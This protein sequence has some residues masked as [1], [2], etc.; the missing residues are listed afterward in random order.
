MI[1]KQN[2]LEF[3]KEKR[4]TRYHISSDLKDHLNKKIRHTIETQCDANAESSL[5]THDV[6]KAVKVMVK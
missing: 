4:L 5:H 2:I 1:I 6:I 3:T